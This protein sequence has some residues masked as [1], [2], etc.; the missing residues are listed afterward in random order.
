MAAP[1]TPLVLLCG[2]LCDQR[3]WLPIAEHL[4]DIAESHIFSFAGFDS[5]EAMASHVL[6][7]IPGKFALAGHSMGGRVA[8][9]VY[10]QAPHRVS[11]LALLNTGVH[12]KR[13]SEVPG[14]Q[15]LLDLAE[16]KGMA[17][18]CD[19]WLPP[20]M[21][22]EGLQNEALMDDLKNMVTSHTPNQFNGEIQA[23]LNRPEAESVLASVVVNTLLLSSEHDAWSPISQHRDMQA[24]VPHSRLVGIDNAGHMSTVEAPEAVAIAMRQWLTQ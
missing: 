22:P 13:E 8:L 5:I 3:I 4:D 11:H 12:P 23:L 20:M 10:K 14:R 9:E 7:N 17:D 15:K 24:L 18:V 6:E 1:K 21:G 19:A 16:A 2:L